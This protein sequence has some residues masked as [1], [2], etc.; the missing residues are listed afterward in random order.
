M[1]KF[2]K[3]YLSKNSNINVNLEKDQSYP[4]HEG[5]TGGFNEKNN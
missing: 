3:F 1:R 5:T 2:H 4:A